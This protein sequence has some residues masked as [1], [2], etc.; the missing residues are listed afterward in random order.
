MFIPL[1]VFWFA[2]PFMMILPSGLSVAT[3][4]GVCEWTISARA[5]RMDVTFWQ[6]SNNPPSS[7]Y[8]DDAMKF[9]IMLHFTCTVPCDGGIACIGVFNFGPREIIHLLC[10]VPLVLICRMHPNICRE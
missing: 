3:S 10:F 9:F 7:S 4:V 1:D 6:V 8:V 2:V 5:V